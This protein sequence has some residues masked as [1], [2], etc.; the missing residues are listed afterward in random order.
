VSVIAGE[1]VGAA[2]C[3]DPRVLQ[4]HLT[5]LRTPSSA[6]VSTFGASHRFNS[7]FW[8][9]VLA[10]TSVGQEGLC[11]ASDLVAQ[12][13]GLLSQEERRIVSR[14]PQFPVEDKLRIVLSVLAGEMTVAEAA[15]RNKTSETSVGK[16]KAQFLEG[17]RHGLAAGHTRRRS[18]AMPVSR[19]CQLTGIRAAPTPAGGPGA[20]VR[21]VIRRRPGSHP[22]GRGRRW[23]SMRWSRW[24]PSTPPTGRP[25]ATARSTG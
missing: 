10:S 3:A 13:L 15:R 7:P 25:G 11:R 19:F 22:R 9:F 24:W 16:W 1:H 18:Q 23:S 21:P 8:P 17:G 5:A 4:S 2:A 6:A 14:P 20:V 12:E